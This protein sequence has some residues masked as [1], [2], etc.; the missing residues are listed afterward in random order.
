VG[1]EDFETKQVH[2]IFLC[3]LNVYCTEHIII[4][5]DIKVRGFLPMHHA[6]VL[7][8]AIP[9]WQSFHVPE[10]SPVVLLWEHFFILDLFNDSFTFSE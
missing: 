10:G 7:D 9:L 6:P 2:L 8:T 3:T 5:V 4:C 1:V